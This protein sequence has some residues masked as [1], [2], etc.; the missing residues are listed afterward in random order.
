LKS[1]SYSKWRQWSSN[2]GL[3]IALSLGCASSSAPPVSTPDIDVQSAADKAVQLYDANGD[4]A[5][6]KDELAKSPSVGKSLA[7]YDA[8]HDERVTHEEIVN[9]LGRLVG[10]TAAY[11]T[12]DCT[13][14]LGGRPLPRAVVK[15]IPLE[16][17]GDSLPLAEGTSDDL[18]VAHPAIA[19]DKLPPKL[20]AALLVFPGL[21]R[22]A[23]T[24]AQT[25][26]PARYNTATE[27]G[28]EVDPS[29]RTGTSARFDLKSN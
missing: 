11:V 25:T 1:Q 13:V 2:G 4:G 27:L 15:L 6:D 21:Y 20:G 28:W 22:V 12:V 23:I 14:T 7:N 19:A 17:F 26:L 29:S 8:N 9:R 3:L 16:I 18:G 24:H 10:R 5:L